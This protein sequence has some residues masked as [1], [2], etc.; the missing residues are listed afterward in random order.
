MYD[1]TGIIGMM[2]TSESGTTTT[3][4]FQRNLL[5]DVIG[6]YNAR[7]EKVGGYAYDAW[8]N[9]TITLNSDGSAIRNPI[10]YRGYYYDEDTKL[11]YLNARY[12]CPEWRRFISPDDTGYLDPETPNG[13]NLYTY[14]G[15][16]P[17]NYADPSGNSIIA[18]ILIGAAIGAVIS[19]G[20]SL[21]SELYQN[22]GDWGK[23]NWNLIAVDTIFGAIDGA[24]SVMGLSVAA[25]LLIQPVLAGVQTV[26][27]AAVS[28]DLH[29]LSVEQVVNAVVFSA[30]MI[31]ASSAFSKYC[32]FK[33][34]YDTFE[35]HQIRNTM[36]D[37]LK[38]A[39]LQKSIDFYK[40][41]STQTRIDGLVASLGYIGFTSTSTFLGVS[42]GL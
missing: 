15:N 42:L 9:C 5:G 22:H 4:Y 41:K 1:E 35:N 27:G 13:L 11:Y 17:V 2:Y 25:S 8:G 32:N 36:D 29:N 12:Y 24:L 6:I 38:T 3:Y 28:D 16:D 21:V 37:H 23:V 14:C 30:L 34:G 39:K 10:R 26:I 31:G 7:G 33:T 19:G 20:F 18:S 40:S